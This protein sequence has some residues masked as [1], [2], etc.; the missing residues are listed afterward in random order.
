MFSQ[1]HQSRYDDYTRLYDNPRESNQYGGRGEGSRKRAHIPVWESEEPAKRYSGSSRGGK[2]PFAPRLSP[3]RPNFKRAPEPLFSAPKSYRRPPPPAREK[4]EFYPSKVSKSSGAPPVKLAS[5]QPAER[6]RLVTAAVASG[7]ARGADP[8][9]LRADREPTHLMV[10]RLELA[11]GAVMKDVKSAHPQHAALFQQQHVLRAMK[12]LVRDRIRTAMIG[13]PV[14]HTA[15]I[16]AAY[17]QMFPLGQDDDVMTKGLMAHTN[18]DFILVETGSE[19]GP[20]RRIRVYCTVFVSWFFPLVF[21]LC[22][23]MVESYV[24]FRSPL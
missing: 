12:Q 2:K 23:I 6:K 13:K 3:P 17:Y 24:C 16:L 22:S 1:G 19:I 20:F 11:L 5:Y 21:A 8:P 4:K 10:G 7:A 14:S 9:V 18:K 15:D